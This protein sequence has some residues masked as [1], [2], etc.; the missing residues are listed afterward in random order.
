MR[1]SLLDILTLSP[2]V[3]SDIVQQHAGSCQRRRDAEISTPDASPALGEGR[4]EI[5]TPDACPGLGPRRTHGLRRGLRTERLKT[6]CIEL[7]CLKIE[8]LNIGTKHE[9]STRR[10]HPH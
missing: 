8:R 10:H 4:V 3:H 6:E 1:P 2:A 9:Q 7:G 5:S